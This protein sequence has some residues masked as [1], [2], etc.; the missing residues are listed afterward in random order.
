MEK[1][2]GLVL[3]GGGG[4]G[5]FQIGVWQALR[6]LNIEIAAVAGTSVGALNAAFIVQDKFDEAYKLWSHMSPDLVFTGDNEIYNELVTFN[7]DFKIWGRYAEYLKK[8]L[9]NRGL[10]VEPLHELIIKHVDEKLIRESPI[11]FGLVTISL[12]DKKPIKIYV[13]DIPEGEIA[14]YLLWSSFLPMFK[15]DNGED[16]RFLDGGF[17]DNLPLDMV[18]QL[19]HKDIIS[20]ELKSFGIKQPL[21]AKDVNIISIIPSDD[22]GSPLDFTEERSQKNLKMGY[23]DA[24]KAFGIYE[25]FNYYLRE[26]PDERYFIDSL[27]ELSEKQIKEMAQ[28]IGVQ[29]GSSQRVLFERL[30]PAFARQFNLDR[31]ATYKE[32]ILKFTELLAV[33]VG[34]ER[35]RT[36]TFK[37]F[38]Q[39]I[40]A[41]LDQTDFRS[42]DYNSIPAFFR[43][44][45]VIKQSFKDELI[46]DWARIFLNRD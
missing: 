46:L 27:L 15:L 38:R 26:I 28:E 29:G 13:D 2:Y 24:L 32:I 19:G 16:K 5:A 34:V 17:Y 6:E 25:G 35:L 3:E 22:I 33:T 23:L 8:T 41:R 45:R 43:R 18:Y 20:V 21:R 11:T 1:S 4:K 42:F 12:T 14:N 36:Y 44:S 30:I 39:E 31:N 7:I 40:L 37:E 10:D 9:S